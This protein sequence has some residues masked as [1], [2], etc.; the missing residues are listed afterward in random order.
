[1]VVGKIGK[2]DEEALA[3]KNGF[4]SEGFNL[5]LGKYF[6][7]EKKQRVCCQQSNGGR[8]L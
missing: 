1:M 4:Q 8:E 2:E 7:P 3:E 5:A 6:C